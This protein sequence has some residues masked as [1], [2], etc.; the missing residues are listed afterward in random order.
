MKAHR[1]LVI[2]HGS[3]GTR[4]ARLLAELGTDVA[5]L[6]TRQIDHPNRYATLIDALTSHQ[7]GAVV[8]SNATA[9]HAASLLA[10]AE[11]GFEGAVLV[12]KPLF[13]HPQTL[14]S[15]PFRHVHVAYN[16]RFHP[17]IQWLRV[18]LQ[19]QPV[20]SVQAYAGQYLPDWRPGTDYRQGYSAHAVQGG[21]V[22]RDLSHELD[23][24]GMLFGRW[25]RLA[26]LG[27]HVSPLEIDS[28]DQFG[29]LYQTTECPM[30]TLQ[31]N[32]LDRPGQRSLTI[33]TAAHTYVADLRQAIIWVDG[34][35]AYRCSVARDD[36]YLTMHRAWLADGQDLCTLDEGME[37]LGLI[38]AAEKAATQSCWIQR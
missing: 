3:I 6:S 17:L 5:V 24:L 26:A 9:T 34:Q 15:L 29:L 32:Y 4:H 31:L 20:L 14:P 30:L 22:L 2:G 36:T 37:T 8:I 38:S 18:Q 16:L 10:L 19:G 7:P 11:A 23:Y 21:G 12:E 28:D 35:E 1:T 33:H 25:Q 27:G 13:D